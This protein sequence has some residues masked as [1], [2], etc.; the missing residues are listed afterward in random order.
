MSER[1]IITDHCPVPAARPYARPLLIAFGWLCVALGAIGVVTP[2]LPTTIFI[3]IAAWAFARSSRRFHDWLYRH[4]VFGPALLDWERHRVIPVKA[5][6]MA[7][8]MMG[9]SIAVVAVLG[10]GSWMAP[11]IMA[12][13]LSPVALYILTRASRAP[14]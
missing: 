10:A 5:K 3:I 2:G 4:R 1:L 7:V 13:C 8:S 11:A 9:L 6:V 12:A 14:I